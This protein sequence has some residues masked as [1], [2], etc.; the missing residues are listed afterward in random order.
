MDGNGVG[1]GAGKSLGP[2]QD[3]L[4]LRQGVSIAK[5]SCPDPCQHENEVLKR[6]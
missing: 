6:D 4:V 3:L 2:A 1:H 5:S